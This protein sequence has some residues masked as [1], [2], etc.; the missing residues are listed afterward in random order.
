MLADPGERLFRYQDISVDFLR[1]GRR[2]ILGH[3]QGLGKTAIACRAL[4]APAMV[5]CPASLVINWRRELEKWR[6]DL[7][8][9]DV[10]IVSYTNPKLK[11]ILRKS[12]HYSLICDEVHYIK[13]LTAKRSVIV[14][15]F[16]RRARH[17][18][19]MSGT[20]V[21]NRPIELWPLLYAMKITDMGYEE[22]AY[23]YAKAYVNPWK[24][25][26]VR[27]HS[28]LKELRRLVAP[29]SLRFTKAEV[30][31]ELPLKTWRIIA[32]DLPTTR[33]ERTR[34]NAQAKDLSRLTIEVAMEAMSDLIHQ[35]GLRK[36]PKALS[37]LRDLLETVPKLIVFAYHRDILAAIMEE[38]SEFHPVVL[39]G[40]MS[41]KKKQAAVDQFQDKKKC[42]V[43][44]GQ[45][46]AAGVGWTMTAASHVVFVEG[47]WV[48]AT[49]DQAS[50]R[51]HR[52]GTT[53]NVTCDVLVVHKTIDEHMMRRCLEKKDV[54]GRIVPDNELSEFTS[55]PF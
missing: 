38:L 24:E 44:V 43:L 42:R 13:T 11:K 6:R 8:P 12:N 54:A 37:Y 25:L 7:T 52:I 46:N 16:I 55:L 28:H 48:P 34:I 14:C 10:E 32:L 53:Q 3:D 19:A 20:L 29:H 40:G 31:P 22:F 50:D 1:G 17:V 27:G 41:V 15:G 35:H 39:Q 33:K 2:R 51:A 30:L 26:D 49:M 36:L 21:P 45:I 5:I 23:R 9:D 47:S 18:I 4:V